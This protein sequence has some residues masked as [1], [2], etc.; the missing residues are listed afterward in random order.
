VKRIKVLSLLSALVL[1]V[2]AGCG[3][4]GQPQSDS[5]SSSSSTRQ[6]VES[7]E[8]EDWREWADFYKVKWSTPDYYED[9]YFAILEGDDVIT[10]VHD[11]D[12]YNEMCVLDIGGICDE[13]T[14]WE[15]LC[16]Y[17]VNEDGYEDILLSDYNDGL[18]YDYVFVYN[19]EIDEFELAENLSNL[20][21]HSDENN[22]SGYESTAY[23]EA[24]APL[25]DKIQR[26]NSF[27]NYYLV[28]INS[29]YDDVYELIV[30]VGD[31]RIFEVYTVGLDDE[32]GW[33]PE[34]LGD[35]ASSADYA[36]VTVDAYDGDDYDG[37][38]T[39]NVC[40]QGARWL[41]AYSLDDEYNLHEELVYEVEE[42]DDYNIDG[43]MLERYSVDD[44]EPLSWIDIAY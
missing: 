25:L 31:D 27:C 35:L 10:V 24:Y 9:L 39:L 4:E 40:V 3:N 44:W 7:D 13:D 43:D 17:D 30:E 34:Y 22:G 8:E 38:L 15:T 23:E 14:V 42:P 37:M 21:G 6:T 32:L 18:T 29:D 11:E 36:Y 5:D 26:E 12:E 16:T 41:Y 20:E 19:T 33:Y 2:C 28:N 1:A